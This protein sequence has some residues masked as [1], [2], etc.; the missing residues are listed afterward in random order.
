MKRW[1]V[2]VAWV[3]AACGDSSGGDGSDGRTGTESTGDASGVPTSGTDVPETDSAP[4][5]GGS[6]TDTAGESSSPTE[7]VQCA[8]DSDCLLMQCR[9]RACVAGVC[10]YEDVADGAPEGEQTPGDCAMSVCDGAGGVQRVADP[11]DVPDDGV[12]CTVDACE[13]MT[14]VHTP[15]S[16]PCYGGPDGTQGV[17]L[18]VGGT[19]TCD[20]ALGDFG[21]CAGEVVPATETCDADHL[22]EDCDGALDEDGPGCVCGDGV[23]SVGAGEVCDDGDVDDD[24]CSAA[25]DAVQEVLGLGPG[26]LHTCAVLSGGAVKCWGVGISGALGYG[27]TVTRG[28]EP[29][30]MGADLPVVDLGAGQTAVEVSG[31]RNHTCAVLAGGALKCWGSNDLGQLGLGFISGSEGDEPGEM[32]DDLPLV[33]LGMNALVAS[34]SVGQDFTCALLVGGAVKCWGFNNRGQLGLGDKQNRGDQPGEMGDALPA[35]DLGAGQTAVTVSAGVD[36]ACAVLSGG[37][38]KCWGGNVAG[39]LGL[40]DLSIRGDQPNEMGDNLPFVD[41]GLGVSVAAV[42]A[43][44]NLTCALLGDGRVK[45][46]GDNSA[47]QLGQGDKMRRG[48]GP[49]EMGDDLPPIDLG[50]VPPVVAVATSFVHACALLDGGAVKCWGRNAFGDLGLGFKTLGVGDE[51]N[52]MGDDLPFVDLGAVTAVQLATQRAAVNSPTTCV[53]LADASVK[54]WGNNQAGS[55]G[56]ETNELGIGDEPGDMGDDLPR[57]RLFSAVW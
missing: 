39:S 4:T 48:D 36:H 29:G 28:D 15:Q 10:V 11:G 6:A 12:A 44:Y 24:V 55:L 45:C 21:A 16:E 42:S 38:L 1:I 26:G 7:P 22:D 13:G 34:V 3:L 41:L 31:G 19:R 43:S 40:G 33:D 32:G 56:L 54:C 20:V 27:D 14:P 46:W 53:R 57:V 50:Q 25:C 49:N 37:G 18:C 51:P 35:V 52:E 47:G 8:A 9:T 23:V 30:E 2:G 5:D 17:G